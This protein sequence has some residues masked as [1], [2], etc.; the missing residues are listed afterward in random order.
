MKKLI[1]ELVLLLALPIGASASDIWGKKPTSH[2]VGYFDYSIPTKYI[3]AP[4]DSDAYCTKRFPG[5]HGYYIK[6]FVTDYT[7][8]TPEFVNLYYLLL[9]NGIASNRY[10]FE[11]V[12]V[13]GHPAA[14]FQY[15]TSAGDFTVLLYHRNGFTLVSSIGSKYASLSAQRSFIL[16]LSEK[17]RYNDPLSEE[18]FVCKGTA[19]KYVNLRSEPNA[20]SQK[21]GSLDAGVV[22][23]VIAPYYT[24]KWHQIEYNGVTCFVSAN[25][26]ELD[27]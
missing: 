19:K 2:R 26:L 10:N 7:D 27:K 4:L 14:I 11:E 1:F 6:L 13:E 8:V 17:I 22:V 21:L 20:D 18:T 12:T 15:P 25:Y 23:N 24:E 16:S 3:D 9:A 5:D